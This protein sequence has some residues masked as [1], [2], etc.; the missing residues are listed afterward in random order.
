MCAANAA[1]A[2]PG[3]EAIPLAS[4]SPPRPRPIR[5]AH[6][7]AASLST[8]T[9]ARQKLLDY[10]RPALKEIRQSATPRIADTFH[11]FLLSLYESLAQ[12]ANAPGGQ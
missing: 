5:P 8:V 6:G 1:C 11:L 2:E 4:R 3:A 12:A 10:G 7:E 9:Q